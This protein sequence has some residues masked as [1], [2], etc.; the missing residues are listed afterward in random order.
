MTLIISSELINFVV[1]GGYNPSF[2]A[3]PM[4]RLIQDTVE[5][6]LAD[7]IIRGNL[8]A[9]QT[10]SFSITGDNTT[11]ENLIPEIK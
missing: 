7:L 2:G 5:Q 9:G 1:Q 11:K 8:N 3:R 6:H 10:I 4:N